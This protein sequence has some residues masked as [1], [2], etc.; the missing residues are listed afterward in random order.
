M[1][2]LKSTLFF[3]IVFAV[4]GFF[5]YWAVVSLQSGTEHVTNQQIKQ[6]QKENEEL[7]EEVDSLTEELGVY[8]PKIEDEISNTT[9]ELIPVPEVPKLTPIIQIV[10]KYKDMIN[11][12]QKMVD[13]NVAMKLKSKG[14]RVGTVQKFLNIYN[15]TSNRVDNDYGKSTEVAVTAFQKAEGLKADGEVGVS[16]FIKMIDWLKKQG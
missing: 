6:L 8:K 5:G 15:S 11:E 14:T 10:Y 3:I 9:E 1:E 12:L 16:T 2:R 4:L 13:E 7:K